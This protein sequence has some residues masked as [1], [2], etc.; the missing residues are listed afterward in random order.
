VSKLKLRLLIFSLAAI[1]ATLISQGTLAFYS[2][3]GTATNVV[4]SGNIK[5]AIH[6][7][8]GDGTPFP[9]E[10]VYVIPG[11]IVSKRATV[12]NICG[13]PFYLRVKLVD[14]IDSEEL[15]SEDCFGID[16]N[17][18][19]WTVREDGYIYY[20]E[21]LEPGAT[22]PPVFTEVEII[23]DKIDN[24]YIGR[25]LTLTV[26]AFA[27]QQENNPAQHPWEAEG[28]PEELEDGE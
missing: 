9:E 17:D 10:G 27:V 26:K 28:W 19:A 22:T 8:S 16:I 25:V 14:E 5:L 4:T 24:K 23:G 11:Q 21:V 6:E 18:S 1:V 7:T 3:I 13:H 12:E 20:N 15:S 2:V